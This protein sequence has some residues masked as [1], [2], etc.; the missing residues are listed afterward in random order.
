MPEVLRSLLEA[1]TRNWQWRSTLG[2]RYGRAPV[3][4]SPSGGLKHLA[5]SVARC[6]G[7]LLAAV[8]ELVRPGHVVW[9]IGANLGIFGVAAAVR[10]GSEGLVY[11]FEPD[12]WLVQLLRRSA[13][14]QAA[15]T[16]P[17]IVVPAAVGEEVAVRTFNIARRSRA[18]SHLGGHGAIGCQS[19]RQSETVVALGVDWL[20]SRIPPPD[21]I[22]IDVEGAELEVLR[23]GQ[24]LLRQRRPR[25]YCEVT[26]RNVPQVTALLTSLGYNLF[27]GDDAAASRQPVRMATFNTIAIPAEETP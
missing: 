8:D 9:D 14:L 12:A 19:T 1:L 18:M 7:P 3:V 21:V 22:K 11:C 20:A 16:A 23:G 27:D 13:F 15:T 6:H 2:P 10:A 24:A 25:I 26:D 17:L 5:M 4:I